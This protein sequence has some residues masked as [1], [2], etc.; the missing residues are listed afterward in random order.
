MDINT[1]E[2]THT[3]TQTP[4]QTYTTNKYSWIR[5]KDHLLRSLRKQENWTQDMLRGTRTHLYVYM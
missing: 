3:N 5:A 4:K 1:Y 2:H